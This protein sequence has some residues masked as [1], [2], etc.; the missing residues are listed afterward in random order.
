MLVSLKR[1]RRSILA[2]VLGITAGIAAACL[3]PLQSAPVTAENQSGSSAS[4]PD[5]RSNTASSSQ[6]ESKTVSVDDPYTPE[7]PAELRRRLTRI[8]Y[9]VTQNADTEPA[10]RNAFWNNKKPGRY[11]CVICDLP[12]FTSQAKYKSGTGWP[13]FFQ[14]ID[15]KHVGTKTDWKMIYPRT[16]VHCA[17]CGSHLGHVFNDGPAP[18]GKRYCMNS[19][20]LKFEPETRNDSKR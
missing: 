4:D 10:F 18:T 13:S 11:D 5:P 19:A 16:E 17:R 9:T 7:S 12:L 14:P 15:A 3:V 6:S 20:A 2:S 1:P 8:Q